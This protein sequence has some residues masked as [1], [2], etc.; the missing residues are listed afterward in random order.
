MKIILAAMSAV[1][2]ILVV[3]LEAALLDKPDAVGRET[4]ASVVPDPSSGS[5]TIGRLGLDCYTAISGVLLCMTE[6]LSLKTEKL[7]NR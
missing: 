5:D 7:T 2:V 4:S 6:N 1:I 3:A